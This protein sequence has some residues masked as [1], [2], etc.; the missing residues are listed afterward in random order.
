MDREFLTLREVAAV[1]GMGYMTVY[2]YVKSHRLE[3]HQIGG[4]WQVTPESLQDFLDERLKG[5]TSVAGSDDGRRTS[6]YVHE[7][8]LCL[9]AGESS[10][11][12]DVVKRAT[13]SGADVERVYLEILSPAMA[14]IGARWAA[15]LIDISVEHQASAIVT[16]LVGQLSSRCSRR[17]RRRGQILIGG[18]SG[19]RHVLALAMLGDLLRL[20]G[21]EVFDLGGDTPAESFVFAAGNMPDLAAIGVSVTS[22]EAEESARST[23]STLRQAIGPNIPVVVGGGAI[24]DAEHARSLGA[25][26]Y[27]MGARGFIELL[28]EITS[29]AKAVKSAATTKA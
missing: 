26:R 18:P 2:R 3:A 16:R 6:D 20:N 1:I 24:R 23:L 25:D 8:E 12:W 17:G 11:A 28:D 7:L 21:W 27:A 29:T 15:G 9:S 4:V 5:K 22:V 10:G 14:N 13:D 19:E